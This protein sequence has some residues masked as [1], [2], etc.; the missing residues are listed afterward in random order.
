MKLIISIYKQAIVLLLLSLSTL[1]Y[2]QEI[3]I[4]DFEELKIQKKLIHKKHPE[5]ITHYKEI[6]QKA[7]KLLKH[8]VFS[9]VNK[10]GIPPSNSKHDYMSI[11]PYWWPNPNT[12]NGL[13]YVRRDGEVN[14]E[15]QNNFT[16]VIEK[17]KFIYAV[18]T[19]CKAYYFSDDIKY[20]QK[21]ITF[22]NAWFL[23]EETKMNP[24]VNYGQYV[25][26]K[27]KGRSFG[28]IEFEGL[29]EV[30]KFLELVKYRG[31]LNKKTEVGMHN[32]FTKYSNWLKNSKLGKGAVVR[33]NNHGTHYDAQLLSILIFL[34]KTDQ[35]KNHLLTLSIPRIFSQIE[36]N[37]SQP[38]ELERT[39]SFSY[40]V[41]NLHGF[42]E[43]VII[44]KRVGVNLWDVVSK[45]GRS[46]KS[47]FQYMVPYL[48]HKKKWKYQQIKDRTHSEE[49]LI[50]DLNTI[51]KVLKDKSFDKTLAV[52]NNKTSK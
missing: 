23:N 50:E 25:P 10:T 52:L 2:A 24:N 21:N 13:P 28:I 51:S 48:T 17:R 18:K 1:T 37:G 36:P 15:T 40:S 49:K 20:A 6:I 31:I 41:M 5:A 3:N 8:K 35:V 30:T 39:K 45:D 46:I 26:G 32:W 7:N 42:L 22:I 9:V 19:L 43:L 38:L 44:G 34:N 14:P 27:S 4:I 29:K 16:D 12:K 47:A 11:G 33:K